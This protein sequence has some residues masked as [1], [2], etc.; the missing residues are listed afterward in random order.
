MLD[1]LWLQK[2]V[3][4]EQRRSWLRNA[5]LESFAQVTKGLVSFGQW[6][7]PTLVGSAHSLGRMNTYTIRFQ[8]LAVVTL[9]FSLASAPAQT[10]SK[11]PEAA[12]S[13]NELK[14]CILRDEALQ[15]QDSKMRS[16]QE[17]HNRSL[18]KVSQEA[19]AL[20]EI[21]RTID[22]TNQS[23]VNAYNLRNAARNKEVDEI[24]GRAEGLRAVA[25][26]LLAEQANH[27][28][29][30]ISKP[31]SL[32]DERAVLKEL[33]RAPNSRRGGQPVPTAVDL[34]R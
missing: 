18:E 14:E 33:G 16:A 17:A 34:K 28:S 1:I 21:L 32:E 11:G 25:A 26:K 7:S 9:L 31:F 10:S 24:N 29:T 5:R 20:A 19:K 23:A 12:L 6:T 22:D 15:E 4:E 27:M 13:R 30:C 3:D 8:S 2:R